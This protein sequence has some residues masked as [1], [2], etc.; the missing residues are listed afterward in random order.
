M[1]QVDRQ[2]EAERLFES[3]LAPL[4]L[5]G[6]LRPGK[7][8]GGV[9]ALGL[10]ERMPS[11]PD[12]LSRTQ[13]ARIRVARKLIRVDTLSAAPTDAEWALS[14]VLHDTVQATHPGFDAAFKKSGPPRLLEIAAATLER[15]PAPASLAEALSRHT[16]LS[17]MFEITRTD[18]ELSWWTGSQRFYGTTPPK[19]LVAWPDL[20]RVSE[21]RTARALMDLP[22]FTFVADVDRFSTV[23][24]GLLARTPLTDLATLTRSAPK[25]SWTGPTVALCKSNVG[26]TLALRALARLPARAVEDVLGRATRALVEAADAR[27]LL[28]VTHI[29]SERALERAR[30]HVAEGHQD[31]LLSDPA[32]P[33]GAMARGL[34]ASAALAWLREHGG[35]LGERDLAS[36]AHALSVEAASGAAQHALSTIERAG[37]VR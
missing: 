24:Y 37:A 13:L 32:S 7:P 20:R 16:W 22:R 3:F 1:A 9:I 14:A 34:G 10:G 35:S 28:V 30:A 33:D 29:L 11:N 2:T 27:S 17:R 15:I 8:F 4:V 26:R 18:V 6:S 19:R 36:L 12:L 25:F 21:L 23:L 5:G 31:P